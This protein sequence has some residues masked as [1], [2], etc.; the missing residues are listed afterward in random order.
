M[1]KIFNKFLIIF[2]LLLLLPM[3]FFS[4]NTKAYAQAEDDYIQNTITV[5]EDG[6][7]SVSIL[8][9]C[10]LP[11]SFPTSVKVGFK[12]QLEA[13]LN[14][15]IEE[16][17]LELNEKYLLEENE[18]F[19]PEK[20]VSFGTAGGKID[21]YVGYEIIYNSVDSFRYYNTLKYSY[22]EGFFTDKVSQVLNNP[23]ND[24]IEVD[25]TTKTVAQ[26]Y[27]DIYK[28]AATT[29]AETFKTSF[30]SIINE[31]SPYFYNDYMTLNRRTKS[32]ANSIAQDSDNYYHHIWVSD[33]NFTPDDAM[34]LS[35]NVIHAGWWYL[36]GTVLPLGIMVIA[37]IVV[38]IVNK[39]KRRDVNI[40]ERKETN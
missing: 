39:N 17:K 25:G 35:L 5:R 10:H 19:N 9:S 1:S 2:S 34:K 36:L 12:I 26:K 33:D 8:M 32:N 11:N 31:Y 15:D 14:I 27:K 22:K 30:D 21:N 6:K 37:I 16:K 18:K 24:M 4:T 23:F 28:S 20:V 38:K 13:L 40:D 29:V 3:V 7:V